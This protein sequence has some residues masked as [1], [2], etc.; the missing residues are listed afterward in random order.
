MSR[1]LTVELSDSAYAALTQRAQESN[2]SPTQLAT[3][4]LEQQLGTQEASREASDANPEAITRGARERFERHFGAVDLGNSSG[5]DNELI[6]AD[7]A[8][9]YADSHEDN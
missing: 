1:L 2:V 8:R 9:A 5:A 6:D 4:V 7:L 3:V